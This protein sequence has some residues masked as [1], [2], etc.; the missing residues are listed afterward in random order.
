M[1]KVSNIFLNGP[2]QTYEIAKKK[3]PTAR[4]MA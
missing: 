3:W 1:E 4:D 2:Y